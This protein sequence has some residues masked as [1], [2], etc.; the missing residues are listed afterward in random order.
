MNKLWLTD[1]LDCSVIICVKLAGFLTCVAHLKSSHKIKSADRADFWLVRP[2]NIHIFNRNRSAQ[3]LFV[4]VV[5]MGGQ[6]YFQKQE[7]WF[8]QLSFYV[9]Q[10]PRSETPVGLF[11]PLPS[12]QDSCL[13]A[14]WI[15][16]VW[17]TL[18][19]CDQPPQSFALLLKS[20]LKQVWSEFYSYKSLPQ[21]PRWRFV[22]L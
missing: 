21:I 9:M 3:L 2:S 19:I 14:A 12:P 16:I 10:D 5:L 7:S 13:H 15:L 1:I 11:P 6:V 22:V 8:L 20:F 17:P 4:C 18:N